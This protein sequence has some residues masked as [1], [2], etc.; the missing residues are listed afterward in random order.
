MGVNDSPALKIADVGIT[1]AASATAVSRGVADIVL[2]GDDLSPLTAL[3][4][5]GR[6]VLLRPREFY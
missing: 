6:S 5:S 3:F 2:L 4:A 1:L